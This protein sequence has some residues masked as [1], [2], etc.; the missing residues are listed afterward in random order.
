MINREKK[1]WEPDPFLSDES[2]YCIKG[3]KINIK[4]KDGEAFPG[5][6]VATYTSK[7]YNWI[8][9]WPPQYSIPEVSRLAM[10]KNDV[11]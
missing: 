1:P 2:I 8:A 6:M 4:F 3:Q 5:N 11:I 10:G 9:D 7:W